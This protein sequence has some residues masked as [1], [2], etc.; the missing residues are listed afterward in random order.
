MFF[1]LICWVKITWTSN[2]WV[3]LHCI[4]HSS[5]LVKTFFKRPGSWNLASASSGSGE[6]VVSF[7][8]CLILFRG[9]FG[10]IIKVKESVFY[11]HFA[12][13]ETTIE[14][15]WRK[16]N[17]HYFLSLKKKQDW[18]FQFN[19]F[20]I[21]WLLQALWDSQLFWLNLSSVWEIIYTRFIPFFFFFEKLAW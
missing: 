11:T 15:K 1:P 6:L 8:S 9:I 13:N 17:P 7:P 19:T 20:E 12:F 2:K 16:F 14:F 3:G 5:D 4:F 10:K 18:H 21:P